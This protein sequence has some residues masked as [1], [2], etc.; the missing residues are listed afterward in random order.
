MQGATC[1]PKTWRTYAIDFVA[2]CHGGIEDLAEIGNWL[3]SNP[4]SGY[5]Q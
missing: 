4:S 2:A 1:L 3:P 5:E